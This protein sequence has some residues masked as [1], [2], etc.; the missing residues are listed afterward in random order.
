VLLDREVVADFEQWGVHAFTTTRA[1]GSFSTDTREPVRGVMTRWCAL[2]EE[3]AAYGPR[4]ATA[5]QVHGSRVLAHGGDWEGWLRVEGVDGHVS[6][7]PG[8]ALAVTIADCVP[9][10]IAHPSGVIALL[11]SGWR[12]TACRIVELGIAEFERSGLAARDL[13][14]HLG[15][16]ICGGCYEVSAEVYGKLT[17]RPVVANS[18]VNLR[19]LIADH[20]RAAGVRKITVSPWC[21]RCDNDRFFSHRAG[22]EGRQLAVMI[23]AR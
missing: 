18:C 5:R 15:P 3:L 8:T 17:G 21:T 2:R 23:A 4:L 22:D 20:A 14:L 13:H 6:S 9:V 1:A 11:H 19:G 7:V 16:A 10:F 12:G